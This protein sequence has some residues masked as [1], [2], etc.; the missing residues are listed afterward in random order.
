MSRRLAYAPDTRLGAAIY[1]RPHGNLD[2]IRWTCCGRE[3]IVDRDRLNDI[4]HGKVKRCPFCREGMAVAENE[5]KHA[6]EV[7]SSLPVS[8]GL[9][10]NIWGYPNAA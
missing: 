7:L 5:A 4:K 1:L 2:L 9:K 6:F 10:R 3:E 8:P